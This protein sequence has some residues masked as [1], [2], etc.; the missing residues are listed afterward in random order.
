MKE[1]FISTP[2]EGEKLF[3]K[4]STFENILKEDESPK[5]EA[6]YIN[7]TNFPNYD[8]TKTEV[9]NLKYLRRNG[10]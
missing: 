6:I 4:N 10:K 7:E 3:L 9:R 2:R 1:K 8:V 5:K